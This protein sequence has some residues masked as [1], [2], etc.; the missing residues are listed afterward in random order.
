M[1]AYPIDT[2]YIHYPAIYTSLTRRTSWQ[3]PV[4]APVVVCPSPA[5]PVERRIP[6]VSAVLPY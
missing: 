6:V 1:Y 2:T 4:T 3:P 5:Y